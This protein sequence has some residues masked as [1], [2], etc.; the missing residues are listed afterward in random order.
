MHRWAK[1]VLI[2]KKKRETYD[3]KSIIINLFQIASVEIVFQVNFVIVIVK[4]A[5][6]RYS[7]WR[8][9]KKKR[10]AQH[11]ARINAQ[12]K[13]LSLRKS[14]VF[15]DISLVLVHPAGARLGLLQTK[16][17]LI[18]MLNKYEL[19]PNEKTLIPME[20]DV[21]APLTSPVGGGI[22]LNIRKLD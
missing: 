8:R 3:Y 13:L 9:K 1:A 22:H 7:L 6:L 12:T 15:W 20:L 18:T 5:T 14:N 2:E 4:L 11:R 19:S 21:K 10:I 16:L 17:G